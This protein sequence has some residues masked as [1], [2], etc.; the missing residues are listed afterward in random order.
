MGSVPSGSKREEFYP[1]EE[2][3]SWTTKKN[4]TGVNLLGYL[5]ILEGEV[6]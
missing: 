2:V 3:K 4:L 6:K 5:N 1:I